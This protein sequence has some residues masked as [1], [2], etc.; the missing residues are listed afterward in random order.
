MIYDLKICWGGS[1]G[2]QTNELAKSKCNVVGTH[3]NELN[4]AESLNI[5]DLN[6]TKSK[7][8]SKISQKKFIGEEFK[9]IEGSYKGFYISSLFSCLQ[10]TYSVDKNLVFF[11]LFIKFSCTGTFEIYNFK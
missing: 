11:F 2:F 5:L 8:A 4:N 9:E 6:N 1:I 3:G 7:G 10:V